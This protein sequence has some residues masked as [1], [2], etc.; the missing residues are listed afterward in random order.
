MRIHYKD[1]REKQIILDLC[2]GKSDFA[3]C[4]FACVQ[5]PYKWTAATFSIVLFYFSPLCG[6][7]KINIRTL[8]EIK[9]NLSICFVK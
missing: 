6:V 5:S 3:Y 8:I 7:E 9:L 1:T 4:L 2:K